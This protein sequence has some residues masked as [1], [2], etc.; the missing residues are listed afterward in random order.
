MPEPETLWVGGG[1][2]SSQRL[3]TRFSNLLMPNR[4]NDNEL[5]RNRNGIATAASRGCGWHQAICE[6]LLVIII[7][8]LLPRSRRV[9]RKI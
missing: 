2:S 3:K 1:D 9:L 6:R 7:N 4:L 5:A 8:R